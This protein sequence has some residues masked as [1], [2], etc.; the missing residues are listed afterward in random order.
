MACL[1]NGLI[2]THMLEPDAGQSRKCKT[3]R[4][5]DAILLLEETDGVFHTAAASW[6]HPSFSRRPH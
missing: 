1:I 4:T 5:G 2:I 6:E 3:I